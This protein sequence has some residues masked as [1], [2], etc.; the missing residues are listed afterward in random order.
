MQAWGRMRALGEATAAADPDGQARVPSDIFEQLRV[1]GVEA[2]LAQLM[3]ILLMGD[4][5]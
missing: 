5:A 2:Q 3:S 4:S 1:A